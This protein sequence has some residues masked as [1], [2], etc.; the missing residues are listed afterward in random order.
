M[1]LVLVLLAVSFLVAVT[2]QLGSSVNWQMQVSAHQGTVVRLDAMLLSGL[3]LARTALW[4]DQQKNDFDCRLDDW[5]AFKQE[6]LTGLFPDG[7]LEVQVTDLSGL[8]QV[9]GLAVTAEERKKQEQKEASGESRTPAQ[10]EQDQKK[11]EKIQRDVWK[12]FLLSGN[13]AVEDED[14][15][16]GLLDTLA[17]WLDEDDEEREYGAETG[18]YGSLQSPYASANRA[19]LFLEELLLVKGWDKKLLYGD[20]EHS[21]IIDYL[22]IYGRDGKININTAPVPVLLAL[23][24]E[25][26]EEMASDL[27][28]FSSDKDNEGMLAQSDWYKQVSGFPGDIT[29]DPELITTESSFFMVTITAGINGVERT[30]TGIIQRMESSEQTLLYWKVQ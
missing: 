27:V 16:E 4:A 1:A 9:N 25:M 14:V 13:F 17:D 2:V 3:Q 24:A 8:L 20:E 28:D 18:Y 22:T 29:F 15:A 21:G 10:E 23:H 5:G 26:T 12:R 19:I 11:F 30:G 6:V 7:S